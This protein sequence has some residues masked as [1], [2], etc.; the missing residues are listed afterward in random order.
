MVGLNPNL[1]IMPYKDPE[2]QK[3]AVARYFKENQTRLQA[4]LQSRR[5]L[6]RQFIHETKH[7]KP[8]V[9]CH[10][11]FPHYIL[12]FDHLPG[13][14]KKFNVSNASNASSLQAIQDEVKKCELVCANCHRHRTF[15]RLAK[16]KK[17]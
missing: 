9:D 14:E 4:V 2:K 13:F 8:C 1:G 5:A 6:W 12:D 11:I 17:G 10:E 7:N 16:E 3:A 15:M